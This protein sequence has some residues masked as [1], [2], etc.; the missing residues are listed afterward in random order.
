MYVTVGVSNLYVTLGVS[1]S[2]YHNLHYRPRTMYVCHCG[3]VRLVCHSG[4]VLLSITTT[5]MV[6]YET[7]M[8]RMSLW[9]CQVSMSLWV[10]PV[11]HYYYSHGYLRTRYVCHRGCVRLVCHCGCVLLSITTTSMVNQEPGGYVNVGVSNL[12]VNLGVSSSIYH[13][14]HCKHLRTMH[15]CHCGCVRIV[16]H[17]GCVL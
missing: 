14:L 3:C 17:S 15:V 13:N 16:C 11:K 12:Y 10:C 8:Y 5:I 4:C 6:N 7:Y 1:S 9:V 2:I